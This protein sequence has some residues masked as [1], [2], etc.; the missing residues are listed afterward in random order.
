LLIHTAWPRHASARNEGNRR[1]L[2]GAE[3]AL[4]VEWHVAAATTKGIPMD[5]I[6]DELRG[7]FSDQADRAQWG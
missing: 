4:R 3:G 5:A 6:A 1:I 7:S 2:I